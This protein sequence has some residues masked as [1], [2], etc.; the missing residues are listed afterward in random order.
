MSRILLV[1]DH[2]PVCIS[3]QTMIEGMGHETLT[4]STGKQA[5][6]LQKTK[7]VDVLVTDIFMPD[8]DGYELIQRF[9]HD[10][11]AVKI[12]AISGGIPRSPGGPYLEV[13]KKMGAQ[14]VLR[15]PFGMAQFIE[16]INQATTN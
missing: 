11:P 8:M 5:L 12:I 6:N 13:A 7:P 1:D 9:R 2:E 3:L 4:A 14:S 10:Y 16:A 15:K